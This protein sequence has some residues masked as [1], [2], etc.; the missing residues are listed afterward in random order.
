MEFSSQLI[1]IIALFLTGAGSTVAIY[2][3]FN[4]DMALAKFRISTLEKQCEHLANK[5]EAQD[6]NI[7]KLLSELKDD[8][9]G[10]RL[11]IEQ[12]KA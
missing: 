10:L 5:V 7:S 6:G 4:N 9:H 8:I 12:N 1:S 11:L 3:K 2:V